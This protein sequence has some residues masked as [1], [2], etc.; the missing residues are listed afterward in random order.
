[1]KL[2]LEKRRPWFLHDSHCFWMG[3]CENM[4]GLGCQCDSAHQ[5]SGEM[6]DWHGRVNRGLMPDYPP[7]EKHKNQKLVLKHMKIKGLA[8]M[9]QTY[10]K[11][12]WVSWLSVQDRHFIPFVFTGLWINTCK[13]VFPLRWALTLAIHST[14]QSHTVTCHY[15]GF[16]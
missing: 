1:M 9:L 13:K 4:S 16:N 10:Q 8:R 6:V 14:M 2:S 15:Y 12:I 11:G 7:I 3:A 5:K